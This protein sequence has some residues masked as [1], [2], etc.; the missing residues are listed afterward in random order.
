MRVINTTKRSPTGHPPNTHTSVDVSS[1]ASLSVCLKY[2]NRQ[3]SFHW[4][5]AV[6]EKIRLDYFSA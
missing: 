6:G 2:D 3:D 5:A 4:K 1:L